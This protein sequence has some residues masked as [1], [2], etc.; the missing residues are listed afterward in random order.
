MISI[1]IDWKDSFDAKKALQR[2]KKIYARFIFCLLYLLVGLVHCFFLLR[3]L[4][5]IGGRLS[6]SEEN[7]YS[8]KK[9]LQMV[10]E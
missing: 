6:L 3:L 4:K 8:R 9:M 5:L 1:F 2:V 10:A 7:C